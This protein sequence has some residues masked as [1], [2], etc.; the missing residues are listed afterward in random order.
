MAGKIFDECITESL[1]IVPNSI[2]LHH[3]AYYHLGR[4]IF[5]CLIH[6]LPFPTWLHEFHFNYIMDFSLDYNT[7]L[8]ET[9]K[10]ISNMVEKI[11]SNEN[12]INEISELEEWALH[13]NIQVYLLY[14]NIFYYFN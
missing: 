7:L 1:V 8:Q 13:R 5:W 10:T 11:Q 2:L 4:L 3:N 14:K 9:N 12:N 6:E